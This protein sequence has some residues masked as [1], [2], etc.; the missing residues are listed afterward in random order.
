MKKLD[1][2]EIKIIIRGEARSYVEEESKRSA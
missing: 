1:G 2:S